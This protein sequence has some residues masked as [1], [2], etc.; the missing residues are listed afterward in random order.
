MPEISKVYD[1][2]LVEQ[3]WYA[4]WEDQGYFKPDTSDKDK[5]SYTIVIPPPNVTGQL[6][7]GHVLNNTMQ[8]VLIRKKRM[9]GFNVLW[10]PGTDHAGIATQN[11]VEKALAKEENKTRHD[12][13][14]EE[15]LKR[16]WDWKETYGARI[17]RQLKRLGAS[18]D[19]SRERFTM[20]DDYSDAVR[21]VFVN[22]YEKDLIYRGEYIINWCP[23]CH[24]ALSD[25]ENI[26]KEKG[27]KLW[28]LRY[29][30]SDGSGELVVATT[31]PET[32]LGD[33]AVAVHP[34]DERYQALIGKTID[35]PLTDRKIVIIADSYVDK[36]FGTGCVKVTPA[37]DPNDFEM[38]NR[39]N[40]ER[41]KVMAEDG[42]MNNNAPEKYRGLERFACRKAVLAD[43][44]EQGFL[45]K[46][47]EHQHSV[48]HCE[49]C[50]TVTEPY[51]STQWFVK[52]DKWVKPALKAVDD[53]ELK[54]YP[55][56]WEKTFA[57]WLENI[58]DWC[59]SRQ[60][61]WGHRIPVWYCNDC[62]EVVVT[63]DA[64]SVCPKCDSKNLR[65]DEDVLD[66][67]F[68]SWLWP[69]ATV[70]WPNN[71]EELKQFFPT[72]T[73]ITA[74]DIIF[75]WVA[76]MVFASL[77]FTG[78]L[79]FN[80]V[81]FHSIVR[82][83]SGKKMSKSLGNSP[84]PI[85]VMDT[86]GADALR[87]TI[88]SLAPT[89]Q[90]ILFGEEKCELGRNFANK[91]WNTARFALMSIGEGPIE[92]VD[93]KDYALEDKWILSR[94]QKASEKIT[95][96]LDD[97]L[98][99][100]EALNTAYHFTWSEV[101]DWYIEFIKPRLADDADET[102]RKAARFVLATV[103]TNMVKLLHPFMPFITE[104]IYS[105]LKE[106]G[107]CMDDA[108]T[109]IYA[110]WPKV[111]E[112]TTDEALENGMA[113][114]QSVIAA[115][116]NLRAEK[117]IP[118]SKKGEVQIHCDDSEKGKWLSSMDAAV[119][120]LSRT[121][122]LEVGPTRNKPAAAASA[123]VEGVSV[124][125]NLEGLID[126]DAEITRIKKEIEKAQG[127]LTSIQ[128][129]LSNERFVQNAPA[130]VVEKE[131]EKIRTTEEKIGKLKEN[132]AVFE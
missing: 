25:E 2:S 106:N 57:H 56:K 58:R 94:F 44:E 99:F 121:D 33:T 112:V 62:E 53:G 90:D 79:P 84:D 28:H 10:Q 113:F 34:D 132:L 80:K 107:C 105:V 9:E 11:V 81:Y 75:F 127:F 21:E 63:L 13:G 17:L 89:G 38:G 26:H 32:M 12:L 66:T 77:E 68:S 69:F 115:V 23:R 30:L 114:I 49:R 74:A 118:P 108:E 76:R 48:G 3:K 103:L 96:I 85:K 60:L 1:P 83:L 93:E 86:Y 92:P 8:D 14:R 19:W 50:K 42:T 29:P 5:P 88:V 129:K 120:A 52:Y 20:D 31:R 61:W 22:L 97:E 131:K 70:G 37:H 36:E 109:V 7:L 91:L 43:L 123:V 39:A 130:A 126:S 73:L 100:N 104:E 102:S 67:W 82:D 59:I 6:T 119:K 78:K 54:F 111:G 35:L 47:E 64:P 41:I 55:K 101:C 18:C 4:L 124:Y 51:L 87:Y 98:N 72:Q 16:V 15:F 95:R 24:T 46:I 27:G 40:L 65:Q 71:E 45:V 110:A 117:N 122:V 116:R 125:L 128:K